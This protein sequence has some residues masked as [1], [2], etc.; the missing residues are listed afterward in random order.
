MECI[1]FWLLFILAS[2]GAVRVLAAIFPHT[3]DAIIEAW[4]EPERDR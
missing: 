4:G 3:W 2:T 1:A